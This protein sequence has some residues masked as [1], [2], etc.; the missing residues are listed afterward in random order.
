MQLTQRQT[1]KKTNKGE[2]N[3][4]AGGKYLDSV[5]SRHMKTQVSL[6]ELLKYMQD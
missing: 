4:L 6:T 1:D 3:L 5:C 2:N